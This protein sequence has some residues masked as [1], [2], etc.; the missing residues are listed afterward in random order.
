MAKDGVIL[1]WARLQLQFS[2]FR[3]LLL[4]RDKEW[5][6]KQVYRINLVEVCIIILKFI[7]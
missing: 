7:T 6:E 3:L 4:G 5:S 1:V 2:F